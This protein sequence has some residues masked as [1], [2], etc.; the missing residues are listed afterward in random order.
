MFSELLA[1]KVDV[2]EWVLQQE[3]TCLGKLLQALLRAASLM[4]IFMKMQPPVNFT[5]GLFLPT[6]ISGHLRS[7]LVMEEHNAWNWEELCDLVCAVRRALESQEQ[8]CCLIG[9]AA[10]TLNAIVNECCFCNY[11]TTKESLRFVIA[12]EIELII[13]IFFVILLVLFSELRVYRLTPSD[14]TDIFYI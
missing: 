5:E 2:S 3:P 10:A 1:R 8:R 13:L 11:T 7:L 6:F 12:S 9:D 14:N 4:S